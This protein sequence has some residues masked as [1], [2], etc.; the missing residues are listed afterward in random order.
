MLGKITYLHRFAQLE[1]SVISKEDKN[2]NTIA[3]QC[4]PEN[5]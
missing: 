2:K 3:T 4:H 5:E 1:Q